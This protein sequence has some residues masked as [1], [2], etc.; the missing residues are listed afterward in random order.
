MK[1]SMDSWR[2]IS[3][4]DKNIKLYYILFVTSFSFVSTEIM[5]RVFLF[6]KLK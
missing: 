6:Q 2:M 4:E 5:H 1:L 3:N